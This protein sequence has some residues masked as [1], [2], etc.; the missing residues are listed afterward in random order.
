MLVPLKEPLHWFIQK[1]R[2]RREELEKVNPCCD[3]KLQSLSA[4]SAKEGGE[5]SFTLQRM[6]LGRIEMKP[7]LHMQ[8]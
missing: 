7:A 2:H 4:L 6:P 8:L 3:Q 1:A 5:H